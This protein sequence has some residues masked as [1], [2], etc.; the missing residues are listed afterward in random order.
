MTVVVEDAVRQAARRLS[1]QGIQS[2]FLDARLLM[3]HVLGA[4]TAGVIAKGRD[5]LSLDEQQA[6]EVLLERR[7]ARE[8]VAFIFGHKE[9]WGQSFEVSPRTLVPRPDSEALIEAA[10]RYRGAGAQ[11]EALRILD[12]GTGT[13]CLL[14]SLLSEW[15]AATG[16]G[17]DIDPHAV[18]LAQRNAERLQL[19]DRAV[20]V[21]SDWTA[22][23][24]GMFDL[25]ISNP[26]YIPQSDLSS[27]MADVS[28]Y[29][30]ERA[31][32]GGEDGLDAY[33]ALAIL[34]PKV[35]KPDAILVLEV[36]HDQAESVRNLVF[37]GRE[38][39]FLGFEVDLAGFRRC[40]VGQKVN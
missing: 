37:S 9:F 5:R 30:P 14:L 11:T 15:P 1:D 10:I 4:D 3:E 40:V 20:F 36:G 28:Q 24:D 21:E 6:F 26:P 17:C 7:L 23:V 35:L 29:E 19:A 31:L 2:A 38:L 12:L 32:S 34:L 25:V 13:G 22:R 16:I 8:P 39:Q 18:L 27:L 33:R